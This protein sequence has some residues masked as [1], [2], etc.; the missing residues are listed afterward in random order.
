MK[1]DELLRMW[2]KDHAEGREGQAVACEH[3]YRSGKLA[4]VADRMASVHRAAAAVYRAALEE[5]DRPE[6]ATQRA[7]NPVATCPHYEYHVML[8]P[9]GPRCTCGLGLDPSGDD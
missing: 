6:Q 1:P 5:A 9:G 7:P 2:L 8:R 4:A 3:S